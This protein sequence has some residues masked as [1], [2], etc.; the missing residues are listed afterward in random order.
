MKDKKVATPFNP[1][2]RAISYVKNALP[3]IECCSYCNSNVVITTNDEVYGK[4]YGEYPWIYYCTN[5]EAFV[6][7][8]PYTNIPLGTLA[9]KQLRTAR[10]HAKDPFNKI[11]QS[12]LTTRTEMY[13]KLAKYLNIEREHCHFGW[14]TFEQC[15]KLIGFNYMELL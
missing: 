6:G 7:I 4:T 8:H 5:C 2:K 3:P 11:W 15:Q 1:S 14:F 13:D 10:K 12:G 9:D